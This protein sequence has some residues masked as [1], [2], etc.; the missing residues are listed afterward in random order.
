MSLSSITTSGSENTLPVQDEASKSAETH[1]KTFKSA[2]FPLGPNGETY[3]VGTIKGQVANRIITVGDRHRAKLL[4]SFLDVT[5][6]EFTSGRGFSTFTGLKNG[7]PITIMGTGMGIPMMDFMVR[8]TRAV[9]EGDMIYCRF[10]TCGTPKK[11]SPVGTVAVSDGAYM[12]RRNIDA[13]HEDRVEGQ[14]YYDYSKVIDFDKEIS[15]KLTE[16]LSETFK[17]DETEVHTGTNATAESFYSSQGR[18]DPRFDDR[19]ETLFDDIA[20]KYPDTLLLEME[21]FMLAHLAQ[22]SRGTIRAG[23]CALILANRH[24]HDFLEA[25]R[26]K[27]LERAVGQA[28]V[29]FMAALPIENDDPGRHGTVWHHAWKKYQQDSTS[30][31]HHH[32]HHHHHHHEHSTNGSALSAVSASAGSEQSQSPRRASKRKAPAE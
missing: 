1:A 26:I 23:C 19:N 11:E 22:A 14:S 3:H 25:S 29:E 21:G 27:T 8:E 31:T 20:V 4:S 2:N 12:I 15:A 10:G 18:I 17:D 9:T 16:K 5:C 30:A 32:H 6:F 28:M 13:F 7:V 24:S